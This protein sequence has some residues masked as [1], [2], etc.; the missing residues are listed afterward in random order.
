MIDIRYIKFQLLAA[1]TCWVFFLLNRLGGVATDPKVS[2]FSFVLSVLFTS[3]VTVR[4]PVF[5][6]YYNATSE[7]DIRKYGGFANGQS[8][9]VMA[10]FVAGVTAAVV[11]YAFGVE[12]VGAHAFMGA[13]SA[14]VV[15]G[16]HKKKR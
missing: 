12:N 9:P 8:A 1:V 13:V 11:L 6:S 7:S 4:L 16:Y 5:R 14:G 3:L 2:I 10:G 15:S